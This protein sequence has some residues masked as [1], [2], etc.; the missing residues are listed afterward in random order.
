[1]TLDVADKFRPE[2]GRPS[3]GQ[4]CLGAEVQSVAQR[5]KDSAAV[6]IASDT[7]RIEVLRHRLQRTHAIRVITSQ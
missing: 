2:I 3:N 5:P 7:A 4:H 6:S 1:M